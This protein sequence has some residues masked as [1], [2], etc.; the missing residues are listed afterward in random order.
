[1]QVRAWYAYCDDVPRWRDIVWYPAVMRRSEGPEPLYEGYER[2]KSPEARMVEVVDVA[3]AVQ[4]Y[5]T[6][7]PQ[8]IT[9]KPAEERPSRGSRSRHWDEKR[10][11][12]Q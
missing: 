7:C 4:G 2:G 1:M 6:R 10:P 11:P 12:G 8:T 5:V 3:Q 9:G